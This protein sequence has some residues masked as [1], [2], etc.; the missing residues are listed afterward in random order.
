[1]AMSNS[2]QSC[3]MT[4]PPMARIMWT[5]KAWLCSFPS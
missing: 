3:C 1:M 4:V 2:T 5:M